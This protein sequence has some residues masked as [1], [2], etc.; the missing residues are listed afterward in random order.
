[1]PGDCL[2]DTQFDIGS[3]SPAAVG[4][5]FV[6]GETSPPRLTHDNGGGP[7]KLSRLDFTQRL[8]EGVT[9][10]DQASTL[11]RLDDKLFIS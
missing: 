4:A 1:V 2:V 8:R 11:I 10:R 3:V 9:P 5:L 6:G 7:G